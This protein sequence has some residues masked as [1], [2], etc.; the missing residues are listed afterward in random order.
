LD[1]GFNRD[2]L[3]R[4]FGTLSAAWEGVSRHLRTLPRREA[5]YLWTRAEHVGELLE[6]LHALLGV[7]GERPRLEAFDLVAA[8]GAGKTFDIQA[9]HSGKCL[10]VPG[11]SRADGTRVQQ[12]ECLEVPNQHWQFIAVEKGWVKI[13]NVHSG[14]CLQVEGA[15]RENG[16][17]VVQ[18]ADT[19]R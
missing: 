12:W 11:G 17:R 16:A 7:N 6:R 8:I 10:D 13:V 4:D 9:R 3:R 2:H 5:R 14:K 15:A 19:G 18:G 1:G